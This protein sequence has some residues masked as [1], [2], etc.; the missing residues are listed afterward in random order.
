MRL[1]HWIPVLWL[2]AAALALSAAL[3]RYL[4]FGEI[5]WEIT[6]AGVFLLAMGLGQ[7]TR[8]RSDA[9]AKPPPES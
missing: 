5:S 6:A 8:P 3:V 9:A 4:R 7:L 2:V 1:Q